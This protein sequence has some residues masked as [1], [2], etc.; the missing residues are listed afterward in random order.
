ME[1][2]SFGPLYSKKAKVLILGS[3][4]SVVSL[5]MQQ[6][7]AHP[8][9]AFWPILFTYFDEPVSEAYEDRKQLILTHEIALWDVLSCCERE[10]SMDTAIRN[11]KA[12]DLDALL[13]ECPGIRTILLNGSKAYEQYRKNFSHPHNVLRLPSTSPAMT[14]PFSEKFTIWKNALDIAFEK[15]EEIK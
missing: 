15:G 7:Y 11:P 10:G 6:Y 3:M 2:V 5:R 4:P 1:C 13:S 9:N 14:M 8:R 12:N